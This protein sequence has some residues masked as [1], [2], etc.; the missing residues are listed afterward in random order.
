[1]QNDAGS[2]AF[3]ASAASAMGYYSSYT[4]GVYRFDAS[5]G[6]I[7]LIARLG[8]PV[9]DLPGS[10]FYKLFDPPAIDP[11]S[12]VIFHAWITGVT[13]QG[14]FRAPPATPVTSLVLRGDPVPEGGGVLFKRFV[15]PATNV[16]GTLGFRA[17]NLSG[18]PRHEVV[19]LRNGTAPE[20]VAFAGDPAPVPGGGVVFTNFKSPALNDNDVVVFPATLS[21]S[22]AANAGVIACQR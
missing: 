20:T 13:Y 2:V 16:A 4:D 8:D 21:G 12:A 1:V 14:I 19:V 7:A 17:D 10:T 6:T 11:S 5:S 3:I 22:G 9:P 18:L 15:A